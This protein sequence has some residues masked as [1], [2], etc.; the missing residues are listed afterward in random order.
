VVP[1]TRAVSE[2]F[3]DFNVAHERTAQGYTDNWY[4]AEDMDDQ[5]HTYTVTV[6]ANDGDLYFTVESYY[7]S[8]VPDGCIGGYI[9]YEWEGETVRDWYD[10]PVVYF[11]VYKST[12]IYSPVESAYYMEYFHTPLKI[13]E[14]DY[15]AGDE[16]LV[17]ITYHWL[18]SPHPDYTFKVHSKQDLTIRDENQQT[19]QIHMDGQSPSGFL[20]SNYTGMTSTDFTPAPEPFPHQNDTVTDPEEPVTDPEEPVTD[21]EEPTDPNTDTTDNSTE[22][23]P[24]GPNNNSTEDNST[25]V[26]IDWY[27]YYSY[28]DDNTWDWYYYYDF[29]Y[30]YYCDD[31]N[32]TYW[33]C[34][35]E[36]DVCS[37]LTCDN[38]TCSY[39]FCSGNTTDNCTYPDMTDFYDYYDYYGDYYSNYSDSSSYDYYAYYD[40]FYGYSYDSEV[41]GYGYYLEEW[42]EYYDLDWSSWFDYYY[43][44]DW[45]D[46]YYEYYYLDHHYDYYCYDQDEANCTFTYCEANRT[47]EVNYCTYTT[48][49]ADTCDLI[50][51]EGDTKD[52]CINWDE[53][54][55]E[56]YGD[57]YYYYADWYDYYDWDQFFTCEDGE[58]C[59]DW[60][61]YY[62][63][64][65]GEDCSWWNY[66]YYDELYYNY[67]YYV[68][69]TPYQYGSFPVDLVMPEVPPNERIIE[70]TSFAD[71]MEQSESFEHF[72]FNFWKDPSVLFKGLFGGDDTAAEPEP[73]AED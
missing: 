49:D 73:P 38:D 71:L 14:A 20:V 48:C 53:F 22:P 64:C 60:Y 1:I 55:Y 45:A 8:M 41:Y 59:T 58:N 56:Y 72:W 40:W 43:D 29:H 6:P 31:V 18:G 46:F 7:L 5:E 35:E 63:Q 51:C 9:S 57:D 27:D 54:M 37:Y 67:T 68:Y 3:S 44:F 10:Y 50:W 30:E 16:F 13:A 33:T 34:D 2:C 17:K 28:Y 25:D 65:E 4:D 42:Y 39:Y 32:C 15:S 26:Y 69:H 66:F 52:D 19:N 47:G 70:A 61:D 11:E 36:I 24:W 62:S 21:P 12:N 23:I